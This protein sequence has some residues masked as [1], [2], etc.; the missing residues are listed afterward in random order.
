[1]QHLRADRRLVPL[2]V[3]DRLLDTRQLLRPLVNQLLHVHLLQLAVA[4]RARNRLELRS[5]IPGGRG[6]VDPRRLREVQ[7]HPARLDLDN[8]H[9]GFLRLFE[10][11]DARGAVLGVDAAVYPVHTEARVAEA[12]VDLIH[13]THELREYQR[14]LLG[15]RLDGLD[16]RVHFG[17]ATGPRLRVG[18]V[19]DRH[20]VRVELRPGHHLADA[21]ER[22][23]Q[24]HLVLVRLASREDVADRLL[25]LQPHLMVQLGLGW[26][27]VEFDRLNITRRQGEPLAIRLGSAQQVFCANIIGVALHVA[28]GNSEE[29][30]ERRK[31]LDR[32]EDGRARDDPADARHQGTARHVRLGLGVA[33][34]MA[35]VQDDAVPRD[36]QKRAHGPT[37]ALRQDRVGGDGHLGLAVNATL[38]TVK[39]VNRR[40]RREFLNLGAP[41]GHNRLGNNDQGPT[42]RVL[43]HSGHELD[44]LTQAHLVT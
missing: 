27:H 43:E 32:V 42:H 37:L 34:L 39:E 19:L 44:R 8:K 28:L 22:F 9:S 2:Q 12:R 17:G 38:R 26:I 11:L 40:A 21:Q 23:D 14:L 18:P 10:A 15:V 20:P 24:L 35:L 41:L 33:N 25:R 5:R 7:T 4:V 6:D 31:I 13:L 36:A 30:T 1:M 29:E 3:E 16:E